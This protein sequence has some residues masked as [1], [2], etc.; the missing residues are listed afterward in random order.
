MPN[1]TL[2]SG[3]GTKELIK[4]KFMKEYRQRPLAQ[5][6]VSGLAAACNISRG[7][8]YFHFEDIH[9]L[10]TECEKDLIRILEAPLP[11]V[12]LSSV[13][14]DH[15]K[16]IEFSVLHFRNHVKHLDLCKCFLTGS[17]EGSFRKTWFESVYQ[18]FVRTLNFSTTAS[19]HPP[20]SKRDK[21]AR[22]CAGGF[23]SVLSNWILN[24]CREPAEDI[25]DVLAQA[26]FN[27]VLSSRH[28]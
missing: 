22:F 1:K 16:Y 24:D 2:P 3:H 27:G 8:F 15:D 21:L 23:L 12:I 6:G 25:V 17:E 19:P 28:A 11:E 10:Y 14:M 18:N 5:I 4:I 26:V 9:A 20:P 13:G 7:T